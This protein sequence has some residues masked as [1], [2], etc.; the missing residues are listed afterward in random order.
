MYADEQYING[1]KIAKNCVKS[2]G[3]YLGHDKIQCYE[4]NWLSKLEKLEKLLSVWKRR[5]LTIFGKCTII[6]TLAISKI[7]YNAS[8]LQNPDNE[9][10]KNFQKLYTTSFGKKR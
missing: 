5:N 10:F 8:I 7:Q 9:F 6:N 1:V 2:L 3:I 4:K